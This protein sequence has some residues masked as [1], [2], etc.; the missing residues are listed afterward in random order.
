M[1]PHPPEPPA[2]PTS[3]VSAI[4]T[5]LEASGEWLKQDR[6]EAAARG[7][8]SSPE[9]DASIRLYEDAALLFREA[10]HGL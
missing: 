6:A 1:E 4:V 5:W 3:A 8:R 10:Y 2:L 7:R 9:Q